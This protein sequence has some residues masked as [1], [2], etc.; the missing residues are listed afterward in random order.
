MWRCVEEKQT[1]VQSKL[2][3]R[4]WT[5]QMLRKDSSAT[6]KQ[7]LSCNHQGQ[8]RRGRLRRSWRRITYQDASTVGRTWRELKANAGNQVCWDWFMK[9]LALKLNNRNCVTVGIHMI[10]RTDLFMKIISQSI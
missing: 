4:K 5:G 3:K 6:Q 2:Q 7:V 8:H 9:V 1:T 10:A